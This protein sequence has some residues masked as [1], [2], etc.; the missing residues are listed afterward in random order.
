MT[1]RLALVFL[2]A[3]ASPALA[4]PASSVPAAGKTQVA[5]RLYDEGVEAANQGRWTVALERF[6]GSYD[7]SPR[8]LTL[9][10]LA[11][12]QQQT[13][14]LVESAESYRQFLR[15]TADARYPD[16]RAAA[17]TALEALDGQ[18]GHL[19]IAI[20]NID[21][22]DA[23]LVDRA[24]FPQTALTESLPVNPGAHTVAV[25]RGTRTL[26]ERAVQI[27]PGEQERVELS[28]PGRAIDLSVRDPGPDRPAG[29]VG[30]DDAPRRSSRSRWSSPWLWVG[31]GVA[32]AALGGATYYFTTRDESGAVVVH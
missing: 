22:D 30:R 8:V 18:I 21:H 25:R 27:E 1:S 13:N 24:P 28:V 20:A 31:I 32:A 12:A 10:N 17:Q 15:E 9:F 26:A 5:R 14:R 29:L 3:L 19:R 23:V 7:L 11:G 2:L 16:L 6:A 4:Q